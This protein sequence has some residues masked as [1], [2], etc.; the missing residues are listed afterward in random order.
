MKHLAPIIAG[1]II[2]T[3][4]STEAQQPTNEGRRFSPEQVRS[5]APALEQYTQDRLY[6]DVWNRPGL[7]SRDRS[8]VTLAALI[9]RGEAPEL[10]QYADLAIES[11]VKPA[12]IS[13]VITHLAYYSGWGKA[14]A[15][16]G[17]V[18]EV[19]AK[20]GIE[21]D[22]LAAVRPDPLPLD[23]K[24]EAQRAARVGEQFNTVAPGLVQ[25]TT[26]YLF[27]DLWLRPDLKPRDRSLVTVAALIS[28]GQV[29]QII[30]HLNRAMD[31]GLTEEQASEVITH[32]AF[33]AGW[34]NAMSA[35]P[36]AKGV[37]EKRRS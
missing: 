15:A 6:S 4:T 28:V 10:T 32:L 18:G 24:A 27:R 12:E 2:M 7:S 37:F 33:Y 14:M 35:L 23:E 5:V 36:V 26:D 22:Q 25:Y 13:E 9:A 21:A 31:S 11:G 8:L 3:T 1:A 34:P 29:E 16:V 30:Y 19:F 20:R 17:P